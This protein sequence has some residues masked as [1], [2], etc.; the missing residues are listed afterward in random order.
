MSDISTETGLARQGINTAKL[1]EL[2]SVADTAIA[3]ESTANG[4]DL[5]TTQALANALKT[6]LNAL[7][8]ALRAK[9]VID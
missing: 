6:K 3:N 2:T 8:T 9:G 1:R 5:A 4:T 7:L